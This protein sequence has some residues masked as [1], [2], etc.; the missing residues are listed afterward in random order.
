MY[1]DADHASKDNDRRSLS[2][3]SMMAECTVMNAS[4]SRQHI[5]TLSSN[6]AEYFTMAHGGVPLNSRRQC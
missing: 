5:V 4:S 6:E 1:V 2:G 3:V